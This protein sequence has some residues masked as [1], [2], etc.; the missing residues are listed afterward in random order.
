MDYGAVIEETPD[1]WAVNRYLDM[2]PDEWPQL[3]FNWDLSAE[4]QRFALDGVELSD[5]Q[6]R[7]LRRI[8]FALHSI[9]F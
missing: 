2:P 6:R 9:N 4:S 5:F 7:N 8:R 3:K 1:E